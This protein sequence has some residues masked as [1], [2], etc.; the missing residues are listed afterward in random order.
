MIA[1]SP[2]K[3][4]ESQH[5]DLKGQWLGDSPVPLKKASSTACQG[6]GHGYFGPQAFS[7]SGMAEY[8]A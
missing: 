4:S 7:D 5:K 2:P 8:T 3:T 1:M 6:G